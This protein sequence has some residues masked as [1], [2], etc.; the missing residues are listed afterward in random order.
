MAIEFHCEHCGT[1]VRTG[2]ENAGKR[3]KCPSC[4]QSVYIPTPDDQIETLELAPVDEEE[5]RR[6]QALL[7]ET[8]QLTQELMHDRNVPPESA[9]TAPAPAPTPL[10]DVRL[11]KVVMQERI[12]QYA[13]HM[14]QGD[15][16]KAESLAKEIRRDMKLAEEVMQ[17]MTVDELP[18]PELADIPRPVL[19]G[20]FKQLRGK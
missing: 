8:R 11:A 3:G 15:L 5:E 18:P 10:G 20:F 4:H 16:S 6:K 12:V 9:A 2:E 1:L 17:E 13:R 19:V 14:A 7:E